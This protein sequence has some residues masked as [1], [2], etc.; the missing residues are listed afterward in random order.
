MRLRLRPSLLVSLVV[1]STPALA[2]ND[3]GKGKNKPDP[4]MIAARQKIF[5]LPGLGQL[6]VN[7]INSRDY[8]VVQGG[9]FVVAGLVILIT[10]GADLLCAWLDPRIMENQ[11]R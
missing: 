1:L 8:T 3:Q 10:L 5:G 6:I 2:D 4:A 11:A 7:A 9:V